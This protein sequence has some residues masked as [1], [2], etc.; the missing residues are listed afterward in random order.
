MVG[1]LGSID[2]PNAHTHK[3][4][5]TVLGLT[6]TSSEAHPCVCFQAKGTCPVVRAGGTLTELSSAVMRELEVKAEEEFCR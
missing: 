2:C 5:H 1:K 4:M 6:E 3:I